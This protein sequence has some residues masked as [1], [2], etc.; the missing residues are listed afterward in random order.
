MLPALLLI[1]FYSVLLVIPLITIFSLIKPSKFNINTENNNG[2][3][4]RS[5]FYKIVAIIWL[6]LIFLGAIFAIIQNNID[7]TDYE[8]KDQSHSNVSTK[9]NNIPDNSNNFK[10][11]SVLSQGIEQGTFN[12]SLEEL[13]QNYED[14]LKKMGLYDS[15]EEKTVLHAVTKGNLEDTFTET[16]NENDSMIGILSKTGNIKEVTF[17]RGLP[18]QSHD[19]IDAL[20][21]G[22][23]SFVVGLDPST[24]YYQNHEIF[25]SELQRAAKQFETGEAGDKYEKVGVIGNMQYII[26]IS[27]DVNTQVTL[28]PL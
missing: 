15:S 25:R 28:L 27:E 19:N 17:M 12:V 26:R 24:D 3:Y 11:D 7:N 13:D 20:L 6:G 4:S 9:V 1:I 10:K 2:K 18:I 21:I 23:G 22:V 16:F 5:K 14:L 8:I